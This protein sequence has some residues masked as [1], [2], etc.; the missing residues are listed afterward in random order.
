M[1]SPTHGK[2]NTEQ[3]I[4]LMND[5]YKR[6]LKYDSAYE[7]TVGTDS[8][9]FSD[10]KIVKVLAFVC[11][12]HGGIYFYEVTHVPKISDVRVKLNYETQLS[13]D[14]ANEV[15]EVMS[16]EKEYEN[17]YLNSHFAIHVDAGESNKGKTKELIPG[18]V[19]WIKAYGYDCVVKPDSYTASSIADRISK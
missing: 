6:N 2:V 16:R 4:A 5:F 10:T 14:L 8:Q 18:I 3:M 9:N 11:V 7:M 13:L 15:M 12:G 1:Q 17:L 19:G